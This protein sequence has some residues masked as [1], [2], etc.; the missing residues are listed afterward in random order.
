M[1]GARADRFGWMLPFGDGIDLK[2]RRH[3]KQVALCRGARF[4]TEQRS[5]ALPRRRLARGKLQRF[6]LLPLWEKVASAGTRRLRGAGRSATLPRLRACRMDLHVQYESA[7]HSLDRRHHRKYPPAFAR[8]PTLAL[9]Q[10]PSSD[11]P[12]ASLR[13][14]HLLPQGYGIHTSDLA[15]AISNPCSM[16]AKRFHPSAMVL[17]PGGL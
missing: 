16:Y 14:G 6:H 8:P 9:G 5:T 3:Q 12:S 2:R 17:G 11:R 10:H 7:G 1:P 15:C 4:S 13:G